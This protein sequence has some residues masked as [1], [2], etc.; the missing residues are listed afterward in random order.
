MSSAIPPNLNSVYQNLTGGYRKNLLRFFADRTGAIGQNDTLRWTFP[1]EILL[2]DTLMKYFEFT[3]TAAGTSSTN[4]SRTGTFFPRNSAS[5]IEAITLYINGT[6]YENIVSYNHLFNLIYDN[7]SGFN[8]YMSGLREL[9]AVDP[10]VKFVG[11]E[12]NAAAITATIQ[13]ASNSAPTNADS[14]CCDTK[15]KLQIRN[16]IGAL[17]TL[18]VVCDLRNCEVVVEI[19][20]ASPNIVFKGIEA[21][22]TLTARQATYTID[23]Y[24]MTV[25][26][27]TFDD[28]YYGRALDGLKASGNYTL[29]FKTMSAARSAAT[30]KSGNPNLQFSTT[31]KYLSKL[32]LTILDKDFDAV[33]YLQNQGTS[34]TVASPVFS[35]LM[36]DTQVNIV[37]FN[38]SKYF[39]KNAVGLTDA[40][41]EVN[42]TPV[43]PFPQ[44]LHLI[45]HNNFDA[46]DIEGDVNAADYPGLQSLAQWTKYGFLQAVSFE[47]RDAWKNGIVSGYP[48]PTSQLLNI[49]WNTTFNS[50]V[51]N[52]CILLG[53]AEKVVKARFT[54]SG[55]LIDY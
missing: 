39:M 22:A 12:T 26:K 15:R 21:A 41:I 35:K 30:A 8:Y 47:H 48:N 45:K 19:R 51:T 25:Q 11:A 46:L 31:A 55:V 6:V 3:S 16:W 1:K 13:G 20:Y 4:T 29:T 38:Q 5:I 54:S 37:A 36:A 43:Y 40:Q 7:T 49:K 10:S 27:I 17:K 42:G 2:M 52:N 33:D 18:P 50:V 23:N 9:E 28:D 14:E 32:Y 34:A 53:Y 44:P 24:Y